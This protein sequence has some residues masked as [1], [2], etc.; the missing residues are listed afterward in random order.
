MTARNTSL[1]IT[2]LLLALTSGSC[3]ALAG[4]EQ[5]GPTFG[6][7][8]GIH[9]GLMEHLTNGTNDPV[10]QGTMGITYGYQAGADA[11]LWFLWIKALYIANNVW[12]VDYKS[13]KAPAP[14]VRYLNETLTTPVM[15]MI[16][17]G[18][19]SG[20]VGPFYS[21]PF[22]QKDRRDWG[23]SIAFKTPI[24]SSKLY[25]E[26]MFLGGFIEEPQGGTQVQGQLGLHDRM[27]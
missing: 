13:G 21:F 10:K 6:I 12:A 3:V 9:G 15:Y 16:R 26:F 23:L 8:A 19:Y 1:W 20:G 24:A 11:E 27:F 17:K 7:S 25:F 2:I 18:A 5:T 22:S 14:D 4:E